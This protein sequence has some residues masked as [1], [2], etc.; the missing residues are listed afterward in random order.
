MKNN[1]RNVDL[2]KLAEFI[3]NVNTMEEVIILEKEK[4]YILNA[5]NTFKIMEQNSLCDKKTLSE[6]LKIIINN[7]NA[8]Y[9]TE[10][11]FQESDTYYDVFDRIIYGIDLRL[12]Q[13]LSDEIQKFMLKMVNNNN[14]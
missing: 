4:N 7:Y 2:S 3:K 8:R 10:H 13:I 5:S 14:G 1:T 9:K 12:N 6:T 11:K